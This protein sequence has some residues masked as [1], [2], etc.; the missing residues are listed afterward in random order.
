MFWDADEVVFE[1]GFVALED[2]VY[3]PQETG[4]DDFCVKVFYVEGGVCASEVIECA[5]GVEVFILSFKLLEL[6]SMK[7]RIGA[8]F[9]MPLSDLLAML[10]MGLW[11]HFGVVTKWAS[12]AVFFGVQGKARDGGG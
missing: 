4:F 1:V 2:D 9:R 7:C 12:A 3:F 8:V 10:R 11:G 5:G 6:K